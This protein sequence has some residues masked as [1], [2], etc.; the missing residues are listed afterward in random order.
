[1][2]G[3]AGLGVRQGA[4]TSAQGGSLVLPAATSNGL[5]VAS[6][7]LLGPL[8]NSTVIVIARQA[9]TIGGGGGAALYSE[10][11]AA[12]ND[13][14]K[15]GI[16]NGVQAA[17]F[18]YRNDGGTLLQQNTG[19]TTLHVPHFFAA[20]KNG[21]SHT[22]WLDTLKTTGTFGSASTAFTDAGIVRSLGFDQGDTT[23]NWNG[24]IDLG[25]AWNRSLSAP[26]LL[27]LQANPWQIFKAP[28]RRIWVRK[29]ASGVT[30][31]GNLVKAGIRSSGNYVGVR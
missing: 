23:A 4:G 13:I 18:T 1:M 3:A 16:T 24:F 7:P 10:R 26:E 17:Q 6:G 14:Y 22:T 9:A 11:A 29:P 19:A 21:T 5:A 2:A 15:L 27:S 25:A 28:A 20:V 8:T 30:I 12:G 31:K